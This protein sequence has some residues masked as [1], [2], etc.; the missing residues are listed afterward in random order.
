MRH[1][2]VFVSRF[3]NQRNPAEELIVT[4]IA[5]PE[6]VKEAAIDLVDDLDVAWQQLGEQR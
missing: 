2:Y 5:Q 1:P 3:I 4:R 6:I